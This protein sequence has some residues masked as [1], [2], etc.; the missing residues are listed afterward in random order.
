MAR[1]LPGAVAAQVPYDAP[2]D[3]ALP[4]RDHR[5]PCPRSS[6][7]KSG[8]SNIEKTFDQVELGVSDI[9]AAT[10]QLVQI[11]IGGWIGNHNGV[12]VAEQIDTTDITMFDVDELGI[13]RAI[14]MALEIARTTWTRFTCRSTSTSSTLGTGPAPRPPSQAATPREALRAVRTVAREGL[15]G[16][17]IVEISPPYDY[18]DTTAH[19]GARVVTDTLAT[20]VEHGHL[21]TRL[22]GQK[23]ERTERERN[24]LAAGGEG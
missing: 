14:E 3:A 5:L 24:R 21:G 13:D 6:G 11:S 15:V 2:F 7:S 23:R 4:V 8:P 9:M 19:L 17:D 10:D 1:S 16:M 20:L 18:A 12:N 22:T